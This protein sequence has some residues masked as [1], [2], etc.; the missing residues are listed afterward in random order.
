MT[1]EPIAHW[2]KGLTI[3]FGGGIILVGA[4]DRRLALI[5]DRLK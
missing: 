2:I 1:K 4:T 5:D 3:V